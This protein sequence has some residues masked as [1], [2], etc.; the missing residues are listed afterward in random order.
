MLPLSVVTSRSLSSLLCQFHT[1]TVLSPDALSNR[2]PRASE[3]TSHTLE[4][5]PR[6]T[7]AHWDEAVSQ[8]LTEL[9]L[10]PETMCSPRAPMNRTDLMLALWP[11]STDAIELGTTNGEKSCSRVEITGAWSRGRYRDVSTWC[12]SAWSSRV[13]SRPG[14]T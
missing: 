11:S 14:G 13:T 4:V 12:A 9:S 8:T 5:C 2:S 7:A 10:E 6:M 3:S 1:L